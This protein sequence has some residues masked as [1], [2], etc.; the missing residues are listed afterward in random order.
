MVAFNVGSRQLAAWGDGV[1][2]CGSGEGWMVNW[3]C[4]WIEM[5]QMLNEHWGKCITLSTSCSS[6]ELWHPLMQ[7]DAWWWGGSLWRKFVYRMQQQ[8]TLGIQVDSTRVREITV[9]RLFWK[10]K[11]ASLHYQHDHQHQ[12]INMSHVSC[13]LRL[14]SRFIMCG[15][16]C[17]NF[18]L[19][20]CVQ[21][22]GLG[23]WAMVRV[24]GWILAV[25][26]AGH[27][28]PAAALLLL[29]VIK[30]GFNCSQE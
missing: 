21:C 6:V 27:Q 17:Y 5:R 29:P 13:L 11:S 10:L 7:P 26:A 30:D 18:P 25:P 28:E 23:Q 8:C 12:T 14:E 4:H 15:A 20:S 16:N 19:C 22:A 2:G 3:M 24:I 9:V 1:W